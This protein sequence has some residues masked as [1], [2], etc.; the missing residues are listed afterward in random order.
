ME[1]NVQQFRRWLPEA[2]SLL[3]YEAKT[4]AVLVLI[5]DNNLMIFARWSAS[6]SGAKLFRVPFDGSTISYSRLSDVVW[7]V[8]CVTVRVM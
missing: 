4:T 1:F 3:D 5:N 8:G 7:C 2:R 6:L